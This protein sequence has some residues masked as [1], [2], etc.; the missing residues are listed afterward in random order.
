MGVSSHTP[1]AAHLSALALLTSV[2]EKRAKSPKSTEKA[3][4][5]LSHSCLPKAA[6]P[7]Q[8]TS[9]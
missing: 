1:D 2:G 6:M 9:E 5:R 4:P 8:V 7:A 3:S